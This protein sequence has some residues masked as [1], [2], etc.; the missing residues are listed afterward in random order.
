MA[1]N[2]DYK[3]IHIGCVITY[4]GIPISFGFNSNKTHPMQKRYNK[5]R[6][7]NYDECDCIPKVHAEIAALSKLKK[8]EL[9]P[10]KVELFIYRMMDKDKYGMARPC[11]SCMKAIKDFGIRKIYYTTE[12]GFAKE[13]LE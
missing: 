9:N 7:P 2:S 5:F 1:K 8:N 12:D 11:P 10:K 13:I 3:R 6:I 4:K